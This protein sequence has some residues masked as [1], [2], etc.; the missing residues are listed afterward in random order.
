MNFTF[1]NAG[2]LFAL[3]LILIPII[4]HLFSIKNARVKK[5][6]ETKYIVLAVKKT[7]TKIRLWQFLLLLIRIL[8]VALLVFFFARAVFHKHNNIS[9]QDAA[10]GTYYILLDN[11]YSMGAVNKNT[12]SFERGKE[13]CLKVLKALRS[14]DSVSFALVSKGIEAKVNGVTSN[15]L[16]VENRMKFNVN[17]SGYSSARYSKVPVTLMLNGMKASYGFA[18]V[19]PGKNI[20]K[21]LYADSG[22]RETDTGNVRIENS[23]ALGIDNICYF[24]VSGRQIKKLLLVDG[25]VKI[26]GFLSETFYLNLA[27]NPGQRFSA[28]IVPSV[29]VLNEFRHKILAEYKAV[30]LCNVSSLLPSDVNRLLEYVKSGGSIVY[31][32]GDKID[33]KSY[34]ALDPVI[35]PANITGEEEGILKI[36]EKSASSNHPVLK[37]AG[38]EEIG[39]VQFYRVYRLSP[40]SKCFSFL[41]FANINVPMMLEASKISADSG[42]VII[43]PFPAD[44]DRTDFPLRNAYVPFMQELAK[45]L[46]EGSLRESLSSIYVGDVFKR[47]FETSGLSN[48]VEVT[49]PSGVTKNIKMSGNTFE[50]PFTEKPGI[51]LY[52]YTD[53]KGRKSDYFSV[54][55]DTASGESDLKKISSSGLIKLFPPKTSIYTIKSG[56]N[57]DSDIV[58]IV[59]GEEI[60]MPL[61]IA[62]LFLL[63]VEGMLSIRRLL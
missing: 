27:L 61:L 48:T 2:M 44:R 26:S 31:F 22:E 55:P 60:S 24:T 45:Y 29:C 9:R 15:L 53:K 46:A 13:A 7:I 30:I 18:D 47:K 17:I 56:K 43:F 12:S 42:R 11:S 49:N 37:N 6:P 33:L 14:I 25:D 35:F 40:K 52:K 41:D 21:T 16:E 58:S 36:D 34:G 4:I 59:R 28:E 32:L 51:Y 20:I 50:Y 3:P 39:K 38:T 57:T 23:D 63:T 10:P 5:F 8:I 1:L 19:K 62:L 54:N